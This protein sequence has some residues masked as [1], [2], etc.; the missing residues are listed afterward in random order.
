MCTALASTRAS[1]ATSRCSKAKHVSAQQCRKQLPVCTRCQECVC[2]ALERRRDAV[3][4]SSVA[5]VSAYLVVEHQPNSCSQYPPSN[6]IT[7]TDITVKWDNGDVL[8][9][10]PSAA[11]PEFAHVTKG[12]DAATA[13]PQWTA[14]TYQDQC[15]TK[16]HVLSNGNVQFTW[17]S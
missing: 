7:W 2:A 17:E 4:P 14:H 3:A 15:N 1:A 10:A 5:D 9:S 6:N 8:T 12:V 11:S 13:G 16:G